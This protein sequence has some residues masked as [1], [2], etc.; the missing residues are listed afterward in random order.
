MA[1]NETYN[2]TINGDGSKLNKELET[3]L[4]NLKA[5]ENQNMSKPLKDY[6][7]KIRKAVDLN[8]QLQKIMSKNEGNT[9]VSSKDMNSSLKITQEMTKHMKDLQGVLQDVQKTGLSK[10]IKA[11][12]DMLHQ[13]LNG[14]NGTMNQTIKQQKEFNGLKT[15]RDPNV[16]AMIKDWER[17]GKMPKEYEKSMKSID[18]TKEA[19]KT[20]NKQRN[21]I[22]SANERE[23]RDG[24]YSARDGAEVAKALNQDYDQYRNE[25]KKAKASLKELRKKQ[26]DIAKNQEKANTDYS[27]NK[28]GE[29]EHREQTAYNSALS[30]QYDK[31]I[32]ER[33]KYVSNLKSMTK[34][35]GNNGA[36][37]QQFEQGRVARSRDTFL[38][39]ALERAPSIASHATM[40]VGGA[41][42]L[43]YAQGKSSLEG[44][45]GEEIALGQQTGASD[46]SSLR[47]N[48]FQ[49]SDDR[50]LGFKPSE[51]VKMSSQ[52]MQAIGDKGLPNQEEI[53]TELATGARGMG[54]A[55]TDSYLKS[56]TDIMH[57]GGIDDDVDLKQFQKTVSGGIKESGMKAQA[58]EQLKALSSMSNAMGAQRELSTGDLNSIASLQ[59]TFAESGNKALQGEKGANALTQ[60]QQGLSNAYQDPGMR[61]IMGFGSE[62]TGVTGAWQQRRDLGDPSKLGENLSQFMG[63]Y[64]TATPEQEAAT[65][66]GLMDNFGLSGQ[67]AEEIMK[68]YDKGELSEEELGKKVKEYQDSSEIDKNNKDQSEQQQGQDNKNQSRQEAQSQALYESTG[69]LRNF[70]GMLAGL[71]PVFYQIMVAGEALV[72]SMASSAAM[73]G[74]AYGMK[75]AGGSA[76]RR[77]SSMTR[78]RA[79]KN[80]KSGKGT[81]LGGTPRG[82]KRAGGKSD[83]KSSGSSG[84]V[85]GGMMSGMMM[86][87]MMGNPFG[88][89]DTQEGGQRKGMLGKIGQAGGRMAR[90]GMMP[91]M[92]GSMMSGGQTGGQTDEQGNPTG[93]S[94]MGSMATMMMQMMA[95]EALMNGGIGKLGD[96][97]K[98]GFEKGK[99]VYGKGKDT[100]KKGGA[101]R[102]GKK[103][104]FKFLKGD[105]ALRGFPN[106]A[107]GKLGDLAKSQKVSKV[108]SVLGKGFDK[109]KGFGKRGFGKLSSF[110]GQSPTGTM[111]KT[112]D[113]GKK[114]FGKLK[115]N[116]KI[117]KGLG[118]GTKMLKRAGWIGA[119]VSA[120]DIGSSL[121]TGDKEGASKKFG[122]TV[123]GVVDPLGLGYGN[124]IKDSA[125]GMADRAQNSKGLFGKDGLV[126]FSWSN[127]DKDGKGGFG[128][129]VVG[130][131][132]MG[133]VNGIKSF[134]GG[135]DKA[136]GGGGGGGSS[137]GNPY[138]TSDLKGN[139]NKKK[140]MTA[141]ELRQ[142]NNKSESE[143]LNMFKNLLT[144]WEQS[145][146]EAKGLDTG[147][148]SSDSGDLGS[149]EGSDKKKSPEEWKDDIRKAAKAMGV[150]VSEAD[151]NGIASLIKNESGGDPK[152]QQQIQD[153]NSG[154][155]EAQGLLQYVPS[156]FDAYKVKGNEDIHNGYD[157]LLAFFN[158]KNWKQDYNPNGGWGPTG[159]TRKGGGGGK[160]WSSEPSYTNRSMATL[161]NQQATMTQPTSSN[162]ANV[163]VSINI[164]GG[165]SPTETAQA[166]R[167]RLDSY[168]DSSD[169][170]IF[171]NNYRRT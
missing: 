132:V 164:T 116:S 2:L 130:K 112:L 150:N 37:R 88:G 75:R 78:Q 60:I 10:G 163:S 124:G 104:K 55:D 11:D 64:G 62:Y 39:T 147:G 49:A 6:E 166:V 85:D 107:K 152:I 119:G 153:I 24:K 126:D 100:Y 70:Q 23:R 86:G 18:K 72:A 129:S 61:N 50:G 142:K 141:E 67:Q 151:V 111:S 171:Q 3:I 110:G 87:G 127:G 58:D 52:A 131:P 65:G 20:L 134:F 158:N 121:V 59:G 97:G 114:G 161:Q 48:L 22:T 99:G 148:D 17:L 145:I 28:I 5:I 92:M 115:D 143:N 139:E 135:G 83:E 80:N 79:D 136:K 1:M 34:D 125:E 160:D 146:Q 154:G 45:R 38:G 156:T 25:L 15:T 162:T 30:S 120:L 103:A 42:G 68:L 77:G 122:D 144:R 13:T 76:N 90:F 74:G 140:K 91:M 169:F 8:K 123:G 109:A 44:I 43:Q 40:G 117:G 63:F 31:E 98:K 46:Y 167:D 33:E 66:M 26:D 108:E 12:Y 138:G 36:T 95:M 94:S 57:S 170:D 102:L 84:I 53:T 128:D 106:M 27:S 29:N 118:V 73:M 47:K 113:M 149:G 41:L 71:N 54:V 89:G 9:I 69:A 14:L 32:K 82:R 133:A 137:M 51:L 4:T 81:N 96:L 105:R 56:M 155:N 165:D 159:G 19:N 157:Q 7:Q 101:K 168:F 93:G 35:L 21:R 16:Q